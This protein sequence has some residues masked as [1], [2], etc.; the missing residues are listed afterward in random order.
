MR[1]PRMLCSPFSWGVDGTRV[2]K[3]GGESGEPENFGVEWKKGD[4][5]QLSFTVA[6]HVKC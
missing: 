4:V 2:L 5:V 1:F 6:A 3:W